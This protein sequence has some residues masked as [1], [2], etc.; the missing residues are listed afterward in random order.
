MNI[1]TTTD[2]LVRANKLSDQLIAKLKRIKALWAQIPSVED[3]EEIGKG[4]A[5]LAGSLNEAHEPTMPP[6]SLATP[7]TLTNWSSSSATL[8]AI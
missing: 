6:I 5:A 3:L 8:L 4:A 7:K 2:E 1:K